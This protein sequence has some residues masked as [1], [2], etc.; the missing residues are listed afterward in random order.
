M[1]NYE[2]MLVFKQT[3][4]G[5]E[6]T[7]WDSLLLDAVKTSNLPL[8]KFIFWTN[9]IRS[10][11]GSNYEVEAYVEHLLLAISRSQFAS[12]VYLHEV[13]KVKLIDEV[14]VL[15]TKE[16]IKD[17]RRFFDYIVD[18]CK[19]SHQFISH[20]IPHDVIALLVD[21]DRFDLLNI[22]VDDIRGKVEPTML[23]FFCSQDIYNVAVQKQCKETFFYC[24]NELNFS[25]KET[26][27]F[28]LLDTNWN[29]MVEHVVLHSLFPLTMT[30]FLAWLLKYDTVLEYQMIHQRKIFNRDV[31]DRFMERIS[32][33]HAI[34]KTN[35]YIGRKLIEEEYDLPENTLHYLSSDLVRYKNTNI[36]VITFCLS[37]SIS[38]TIIVELIK[39]GYEP[40]DTTLYQLFSLHD[41]CDKKIYLQK[42]SD[43]FAELLHLLVSKQIKVKKC[44]SFFMIMMM[45]C[46][47]SLKFLPWIK[48]ALEHFFT[49]KLTSGTL[50]NFFN[51]EKKLVEQDCQ[52]DCVYFLL[53]E[54]LHLFQEDVILQMKIIRKID[55]QWW[56]DTEVLA[57]FFDFSFI[58]KFVTSAVAN[59][60]DQD[61]MFRENVYRAHVYEQQPYRRNRQ[62]RRRQFSFR[63]QD[64]PAMKVV[65]FSE[66][67]LLQT[68][69]ALF[70]LQRRNETLMSLLQDF[71]PKY[72]DQLVCDFL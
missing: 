46:F 24:L 61:V 26:H 33:Q 11:F 10:C 52:E 15:A 70:V 68:R 39:K 67:K 30:S 4:D 53:T 38:M 48:F 29:D 45:L 34:L 32:V 37:E 27:F 23:T 1:P 40:D 47:T 63:D 18:K 62:N 5:I 31:F 55:E 50:I 28:E 2:S 59:P 13:Q 41:I 36:N 25:F 7:K 35:E 71:V 56:N 19:H 51:L 20:K 12:F 66:E 16:A 54:H 21:K 72:I 22:I 44:E 9:K 49:E 14:F 69:E 42:Y 43:P 57:R 60:L 3:S 17:D 64:E 65:M 58:R 8:L 6:W